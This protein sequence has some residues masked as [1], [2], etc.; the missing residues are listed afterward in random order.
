MPDD[1]RPLLRNTVDVLPSTEELGRRVAEARAENRPLRVKL[2]LDPTAVSVT[3]GWSVVLSKLRAF[4]DAGHLPVLIIGD[5]TARVGD[6]SGRS[7]TRPMLTPEQID[8]NAADYLAQFG[9]IIHTDDE[10]LELRRNSEWLGALGT[11]GLLELAARSTLARMLE[12]DDFA[13]RYRANEPISLQELMYPL[14]QGWDS[15]NIEADI[16]IGGTDQTFNL[17]VGRDLQEQVGQRPQIVMTHELLVGTDGTQKM[18]QSLGNYV[19]LTDTAD[20][21]Y[22]KTMSI[23]DAA[24]PQWYRLASGLD[25]DVVGDTVAALERGELEPVEAKRRLARAVAARYHGEEAAEAAAERFRAV[26]GRRERPTDAPEHALP[27]GETI[28]LPALLAEA[29]GLPSRSEARRRI[30]EGAVR[31]DGEQLR[32][33]D[34]PRPDLVGRTL[35]VGRR[36]VRLV[37]P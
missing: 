16:E 22:G 9:R 3:L 33:L 14:L 21:M 37:E 5:F 25:E 2:G 15:V 18:S 11:G 8:A 10:R 35:Q 4:Q 23:P 7:K 28:H 31:I 12:R 30:A 13:K 36:F 27:A 17:L 6:P 20:E 1:L 19:G 26:F 34:V 24:M 32:D 29:F